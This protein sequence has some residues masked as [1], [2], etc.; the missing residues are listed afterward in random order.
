[1]SLNLSV[2]LCLLFSG[3]CLVLNRPFLE[4]SEKE[5]HFRAMVFKFLA[6]FCFIIIATLCFFTEGI[7]YTRFWRVVAL[8][9]IFGLIG[10][11]LLAFRHIYEKYYELFFGIGAVSFVLEHFLFI[12]YFVW[13]DQ[14]IIPIATLCFIISFAFA[15]FVLA[16]TGVKGGRLQIGIYVYIAIVCLMSATAISTAIK[17][18]SI[19]S[20]MFALGSICFVASDT[21]I[22]VYNFSQNKD[23][24]LMILL[25]Y[26]YYPAQILIA[27]SVMFV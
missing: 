1:M 10:D 8:G 7:G 14:D 11:L 4:A 22:C 17:T 18:P 6:S 23:F 5:Q 15:T 9:L 19:G 26:L 21:T 24:K 12:G 27:L 13:V 3:T 16:K 20:L 25:H 2:I